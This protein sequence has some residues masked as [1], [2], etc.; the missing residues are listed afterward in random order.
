MGEEDCSGL[1][2]SGVVAW[3]AADAEVGEGKAE[4]WVVADVDVEVEGH[5]L[6]WKVDWRGG[7]VVSSC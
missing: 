3:V 1:R 7:V 4:L 6:A 2:L 5:L